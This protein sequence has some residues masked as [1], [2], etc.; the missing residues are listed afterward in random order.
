MYDIAWA[1][2]FN[3]YNDEDQLDIQQY[4]DFFCKNIA[5]RDFTYHTSDPRIPSFTVR[6]KK[7]QLPHLMGLQHWLNI[8]VRQPEKQ[9]QNLLT[10][11][12]DLEYLMAADDHSWKEYRERIEFLPYI[13]RLLFDA[14]CQVRLVH[15]G[16]RT[17]FTRRNV[18]MFFRKD[19]DNLIYCLEL[20][21]ISKDHHIYVPTSITTHRLKALRDFQAPHGILRVTNVTVT[22]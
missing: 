8:S 16:V 9:L 5:E 20:R 11:E 17:G 7:N 3:G 10:G 18:D 22:P 15:K 2:S 21:K 1:Q 14:E 12:W 19:G 6:L 13:Y 4:A